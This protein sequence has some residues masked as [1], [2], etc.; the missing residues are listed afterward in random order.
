MT[1]NGKGDDEE[2]R[3]NEGELGFLP[4]RTCAICY[5]DQNPTAGAGEAEIM[6]A[7]TGGGVIGSAQTDITNPY[8]AMPCGDVYC[9][10]CLA[11]KLEAEEGEGWT[12]L[13][14]GQVVKECK[15]WGG[16]V[17][18]ET[19]SSRPTTG[20]GNKSVGFAD[21]ED[22]A[23]VEKEQAGD[24][25]GTAMQDVDPKPIEE[26]EEQGVEE[27]YGDLAQTGFAA[28]EDSHLLDDSNQWARQST[29]VNGD[30]AVST[31]QDETEYSDRSDE[32][33][34][35]EEYDEEE[36]LDVAEQ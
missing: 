1:G 11:Q 27:S 7:S 22:E 12:C 13:R 2:G 3:G 20:N 4:E 16:D 10:V 15:P 5:A 33:E 8:E 17:V 23:A 29:L 35:S 25:E 34:Q 14:C 32:D 9:F 18:E 30:S 26:E 31:D 36:D 6:A 28:N 21:M 19:T 24:E